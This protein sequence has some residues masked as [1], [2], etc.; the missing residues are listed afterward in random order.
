MM[1]G[2]FMHIEER[3]GWQA[4]CMY[5]SKKDEGQIALLIFDIAQGSTNVLEIVGEHYRVYHV[6]ISDYISR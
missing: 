3:V 2:G 5:C 1:S 4:G 6:W